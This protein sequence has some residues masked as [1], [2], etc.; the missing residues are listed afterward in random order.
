MADLET[1]IDNR[2]E[3]QYIISGIKQKW[4]NLKIQLQHVNITIS[5]Y[6]NPIH[7]I[8]SL[9][10]LAKIHR[11][12]IGNSTLNKRVFSG[13]K[14]YES[15]YMPGYKSKI[16][17]DFIVS[18]LN[19]YIPVNKETVN[20]FYSVFIGITKKC[21]L[22]CEHCY[23]WNNLNK[24]EILSLDD[25]KIIVKKV[26]D[27]GVSQIQFSGGEPLQRFNDLIKLI[28]YAK[29][30][31]ELWVTT[32]GYK[33]NLENAIRLKEA[34]LTG[35]VISLDHFVSEKHNAFR[36]F[37]KAYYWA[38]EAIKNTR[39]CNLLTCLSLC[40][41]KDFITEDNLLA[42]MKLAKILGV[43][44]VQIL[45]PKPVGHYK[46][47][48]VLLEQKHIDI[49]ESFFKKL[50]FNSDY[51]SYPIITYHGYYQR[52]IGCFNAGYKTIY[53]DTNGDINACP[54]CHNRAGNILNEGFDEN[55]KILRSKGCSSY[56]TYNLL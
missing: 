17:E 23:E 32:S 13:G 22:R 26:Q 10:Y 38:L 52:R 43:S 48:D 33:L 8:K 24:K 40:V 30:D 54:F 5:S 11:Q 2:L 19:D 18:K 46:N 47:K 9:R 21:A 44:F 37:E 35:V 49:L 56:N 34:G 20:R 28:E 39:K 36:H 7:W 14:Y 50:N 42:Y 12:F 55:L 16:Y 41:T 27:R 6:K 3:E 31:T 53:I 1:N 29:K 4:I 25:L 51:S 15:L 45:E